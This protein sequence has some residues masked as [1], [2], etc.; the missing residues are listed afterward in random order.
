MA[1]PALITI[2]TRAIPNRRTNGYRFIKHDTEPDAEILAIA[3]KLIWDFCALI[4]EA[5][6][7]IT[8]VHISF[9]RDH[10]PGDLR[11]AMKFDFS[12]EGSPISVETTYG[13]ISAPHM[14]EDQALKDYVLEPLRND[15]AKKIAQKSNHL[16]EQSSQ[17]EKLLDF[18]GQPE[19]GDLY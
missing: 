7:L 1:M 15:L 13:H 6:S 18:T 5:A 2:E 17:T 16:Q 10:F 12:I 3:W 4:D 8:Q 11:L 19:Y 14:R 9:E